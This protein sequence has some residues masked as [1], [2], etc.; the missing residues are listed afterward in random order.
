M[1]RLHADVSD[2]CPGARRRV[3]E[4]LVV[5]RR[6]RERVPNVP[7]VTGRRAGDDAVRRRAVRGLRTN[8]RAR[9]SETGAP[10]SMSIHWF[11]LPPEFHR[12]A[13]S[14][15]TARVAGASGS[16]PDAVTGLPSARFPAPGTAAQG[17]GRSTGPSAWSMRKPD[18]DPSQA[19][20]HRRPTPS[21]PSSSGPSRRSR[22]GTS[23]PPPPHIR[24]ASAGVG[25]A[26]LYAPNWPITTG[27]TAGIVSSKFCM[28]WGN[29]S[30]AP[31]WRR[32]SK[33]SS[34]D[35]STT[36][37]A[38]TSRGSPT[39]AAFGPFGQRKPMSR[40]RSDRRTGCPRGPGL[41]TRKGFRPSSAASE[42]GRPCR[43]S[44]RSRS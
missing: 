31:G 2:V 24:S 18:A 13:I 34:D 4:Q 12:F 26:Y 27:F 15:S 16:S 40:A 36:G 43:R 1:G 7:G 6:S 5:D 11:G 8:R 32:M 14:P 23:R 9:A 33:K 30:S 3:L 20:A 42:R 38:R 41:P 44:T 35:E 21:C 17:S 29:V 37:L 22:T 25:Y 39:R 10:R 19:A 28:Y